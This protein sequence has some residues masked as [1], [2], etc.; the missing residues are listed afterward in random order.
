MESMDITDLV[1]TKAGYK[2][3]VNNIIK[4]F[5]KTLNRDIPIPRRQVENLK[6]LASLFLNDVK[7]DKPIVVNLDI[8]QGKSTLLMEFVKYIYEIDSTFSTVIVKRTLQEGR[9]FCIQTGLK[10]IEPLKDW[11][12][13]SDEPMKKLE[14][15]YYGDTKVYKESGYSGELR[16]EDVFIAGLLRGFNYNDCLIYEDP[17]TAKN[18]F[19]KLSDSYR[20]YSPVLC[21]EC[22][23]TCG[24]KSSKWAV[25][26]HPA[27]VITHQRLFMSNDLEEISKSI[28]GRKV[29]IIDEKIETKDIGDVLLDQWEAILTRVVAS[30]LSDEMKKEF[31]RIGSYLN[32][33]Q[34]PETSDGTI[35]VIPPYD[36][37]VKFDSKVYGL[38]MENH[39]DIKILEA[40][41]KFINYGGTT[42]RSWH[43]E[44]RKQFSYIRYINLEN[45]TKHFEK[46]IILD[47]TSAR[48]GEVLDEDYKKSDVVFL[49]GLNKTPIGKVNLYHSSQ[50][51][52]KSSLI[53]SNNSTTVEGEKR[54]RK[55]RGDRKFYLKNV[56]LIANEIQDIITVTCEKTL[57][58]CYKAIVDK[59]GGEFNFEDDLKKILTLSKLDSKLYTV[60]HYGAATTGVNDFRDYENIVF[61]G[62]LN[63]GKL[64]YTNKSLAIGSMNSAHLALSEY[65]IDCIQQIGRICV[66]QGEEA[67]V[68]MLFEDDIGLTAELDKH[69]VLQRRKWITKYF[70]G[71][72]NATVAKQTSCWYAVVDELK[73]MN[74]GD[75]LSLK[76]LQDVLESRF[77]ADTIY[78]QIEHSHVKEFMASQFF[79]YNKGQ[80]VF[81]RSFDF[82]VEDLFIPPTF[83]EAK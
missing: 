7:I 1:R 42:S 70:N 63:K 67:N 78:R 74:A 3:H 13:L 29:L 57:I 47:A 2:K 16:R 59:Y 14:D 23:V 28:S 22:T 79:T 26:N 31:E 83:R 36:D 34:Y 76:S 10:E 82:S 61:I 9:D 48:N 49:G 37:V 64:Y 73:K 30:K 15:I 17:K 81:Q 80:R 66:R 40:V 58:I 55:S 62:M 18:W 11:V 5:R 24:A 45:Y 21:K 20:E 50:R 12:A 75:E 41:E 77:K 72:N 60:R 35:V 69:F 4:N 44:G 56:N 38:L 32:G 6:K 71:I 65:I 27:M 46:T 53:I 25:D 51:T 19:G 33:L 68:Y 43:K 39:N 54:F 8:G 52:T